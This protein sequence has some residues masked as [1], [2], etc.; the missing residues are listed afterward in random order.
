M[1][2]KLVRSFIAF[3]V[4]TMLTQMILFGY[5]VTQG[6]INSDNSTKIIALLNGID[7]SAD[8]FEELLRQSEDR[9]Q[10]DFDEILDARKTKG[11][12][13]DI[14]LRSQKEFRDDLT[15]MLANLRE[16]RDRFDTRLVK[17]RRELEEIRD[18]ARNEGIQTVQRT[19]QSL[20]AQQAK[21]QLL[22]MYDDERIDDVVTIVQAMSTDKR[23]DILAEFVTPEEAEKLADILY[24]IGEG[25]PTTSLINQAIEDR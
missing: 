6:V 5:F 25:I 10:P 18:G 22:I 1:I 13:M 11:Y 19:L 15:A 8:Q 23:K 2:P 20:D 14:R 24:R 17:F 3:S 7:I 9:E 16:E 21:E 4:A 12:D